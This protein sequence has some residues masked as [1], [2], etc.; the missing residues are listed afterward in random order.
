MVTGMEISFNNP[1]AILPM[2]V[3]EVTTA[4]DTAL[5]QFRDLIRAIEKVRATSLRR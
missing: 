5:W 2:I 1:F 3:Q 4:F